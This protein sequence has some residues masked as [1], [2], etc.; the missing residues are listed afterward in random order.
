MHRYIQFLI[1]V[2]YASLAFLVYAQPTPL[3][4]STNQANSIWS[5]AGIGANSKP[6][7][8]ELLPPDQAYQFSAFVETP[9]QLRL[10]WIIAPGTFLYKNKLQINLDLNKNVELA[11]FILPAGIVKANAVRP[12]GDIGEVEVYY[13]NLEI[14]VPLQRLSS[15]STNITLTVQYQGC[16]EIG[17]CYPPIT[18]QVSLDLP[19]AESTK[20][21]V[22]NILSNDNW[23]GVIATFFGLGLLLAFTPCVFPMIPILSGIIVGQ[24]NTITTRRAFVLSL[25]YVL[26]MS[27]AYTFAGIMAGLFGQN[28]QA[29]MQNQWI[30]ASFAL[31]FVILS[32]SMFDVYDLQLPSKLQTKITTLSNHQA[33]GSLIGVGIMGL[34]SALIVG[35]CVTPPLAG[36]LIYIGKTGDAFLGGLAL[37]A[38]SLGMGTPLLIIGSSAGHLLPR[39]GAWMNTIKTIF[40]VGMLAIAILMVERIL[41]SFIIMLLWGSL[42]ICAA[43]YMGALRTV[44]TNEPAN[45]NTLWQGIGLVMFIYGTL[46]IIGASAGNDDVMMPLRGIINTNNNAVTKSHL[47]FQSIQTITEL[48]QA[49]AE[50]TAQKRPIIIDFYADWCVSCKELESDT[51]GNEEVQKMLQQFMRLRIDVT[52]NDTNVQALLTHFELI[53]PPALIFYNSNGKELRN[54]RIIGFIPASQFLIQ[55]KSAIQ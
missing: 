49:I 52:Q 3:T 27:A 33:S 11:T 23:W 21:G 43:M 44:S 31:I 41:P 54:L 16:A 28:L 55:A 42:L 24:G 46:I 32:L 17:V 40:G 50:A 5:F 14:N 6:L 12:E 48:K 10:N 26:A 34:L 7:N 47:P 30:L 13:D 8:N 29:M 37:F 2:C 20:Q 38:L 35:P 22:E 9:Q 39:A 51:L 1:I 36:A 45:W 19:K 15:A 25:T 53:G 18:K 4:F